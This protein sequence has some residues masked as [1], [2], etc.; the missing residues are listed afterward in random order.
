MAEVDRA[1]EGHK[2]FERQEWSVAA[3]HYRMALQKSPGDLLLHYRLAIAAS[4]LDLKDEA[5]TEFEWV[6]AHTAASSDE[7]RVA[8]DWLAGARRSVARATV[9]SDADARD[10]R[11]G[12]SGV[13]GRVVWDEGQ[14]AQPLKRFQV[15][16]YAQSPDGTPKGM[17]FH[18]RTDRDGNYKFEKIPAGIYKMTDD[19]VGTPRWRL[20]VEI[21]TGEDALIDLGPDNS[22]NARDD[23]P[24]RS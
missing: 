4:W 9:T 12:D 24:K 2:A 22:V 18:V 19:N 11:V 6:V 20:K 23:F 7:H 1:A 3:S 8:A 14:G 15:H 16:L 17:S 13:H 10:E 5:T 21:R